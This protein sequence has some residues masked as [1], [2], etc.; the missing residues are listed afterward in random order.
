M[1]DQHGIGDPRWQEL[2]GKYVT[3]IGVPVPTLSSPISQS[4]TGDEQLKPLGDSFKVIN[5]ASSNQSVLVTERQRLLS[6]GVEFSRFPEPP[7]TSKSLR[8]GDISQD[9]AQR[10]VCMGNIEVSGVRP[11]CGRYQLPNTHG[12]PL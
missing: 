3:G 5:G 1:S 12:S 9:F 6:V 11:T 4:A 8:S 2:K 7:S 10:E